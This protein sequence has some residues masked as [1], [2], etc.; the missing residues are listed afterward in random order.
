MHSKLQSGIIIDITNELM[1]C[2]NILDLNPHKKTKTNIE[3]VLPSCVCLS[4]AWYP[5][6]VLRC[7]SECHRQSGEV[8]HCW[9]WLKAQMHRKCL[10]RMFWSTPIVLNGL[11]HTKSIMRHLELPWPSYSDLFSILEH[12]MRSQR[13][14]VGFFFC[15]CLERANGIK[16]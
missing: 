14:K 2:D 12:H 16:S 8:T 13:P 6:Y 1:K 11:S 15:S 3:P 10:T 9:L 5:L 4:E 7:M